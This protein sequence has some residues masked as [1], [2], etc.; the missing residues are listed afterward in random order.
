MPIA[1]SLSGCLV[2]RLTLISHLAEAFGWR[3]PAT[4][5][6]RQTV[7]CADEIL[8]PDRVDIA[9]GAAGIWREAPTKNGA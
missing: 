3:K 5:T 8:Q 2:Q 4:K 1:L 6:L 9:H 7:S